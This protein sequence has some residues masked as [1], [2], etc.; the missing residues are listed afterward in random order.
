MLKKTVKG[1]LLAFLV[2]QSSDMMAQFLPAQPAVQ[3]VATPL[4]TI[5]AQAR[6]RSEVR[7][8]LGNPYTK[9]EPIPALFTS[10]RTNLNIGYRWDK[11]NFNIDLRDVRVW[12]QDASSINNSDGNKL[13][14]HQA[15]ADVVLGTT[16]DTNAKFQWFDNL[17]LKV[18]RQEIVYDDVRLLGNLDWLQQGRR[19]DAAILKILKKG[20]DIHA[21]FAMNQN[22]DAFGTVGTAYTPGNANTLN[23]NGTVISAPGVIL[24]SYQ[25]GAKGA[26]TVLTPAQTFA[27]PTP[28]TNGQ[29][30]QYKFFQYLYA[31]RKFNQTKISLL[32]F[33]DDFQQYKD[34]SKTYLSN[35][36]LSS[37][38]PK[39]DGSGDSLYVMKSDTLI[40][41][42]KDYNT[43]NKINTRIT[44]GGQFNTQFGNVSTLKT[45]INGGAYIQTG[46]LSDKAGV[47]RDINASHFF[48]Y[49]LLSKGK[50]SFGPGY[51]YLSGNAANYTRASA[52]ATTVD[53]GVDVDPSK[54]KRFDPLYGTPHRWWGYMDYFY[55]GTGSPKTGLQDLYLRLKY[56][57]NTNF[58]ILVDIHNFMSAA[59]VNLRTGTGAFEKQKKGYGQEIDIVANWQFNRFCNIE[60]GASAF[61]STN[62][63]NVVK[64]FAPDSRETFNKWAYVMLN[65]R[66]DF[67]FQKPQPIT[68]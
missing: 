38:I 25:T 68:N 56:D 11:L 63:L 67:M 42:G 35:S 12:G 44:L 45:V 26:A 47:G 62:T 2:L 39:K 30:N 49:A 43:G 41:K 5:N 54:N 9:G 55:V 58:N 60:M 4:W 34:F 59:D 17:S 33:K 46:K 48:L 1:S 53:G 40:A 6:T 16:A 52:T 8:G 37:I 20:F 31:T 65:F 61:F 18:G 23:V 14:L 27:G 36:R 10:Q 3:P 28:S 22:T 32:A 15:W 64:G 51:E 50:F 19:H 21:G 57:H 29:A 66:P 13:F 7:H 24:T